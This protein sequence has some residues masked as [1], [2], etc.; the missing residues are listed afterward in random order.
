MKQLGALIFIFVLVAAGM[1]LVDYF[2]KKNLS[3]EVSLDAAELKYFND[4]L[5]GRYLSLVGQPIEGFRPNMFMQVWPGLTESDFDQ[6]ETI[7]GKYEFKNGSLIYT[8]RAGGVK[9]SADEAITGKGMETLLENLSGRLS[10]SLVDSA[11]LDNLLAYL[12]EKEEDPNNATIIGK[13]SIGPICPVEQEGEECE[14]P[15]EVYTSR[16]LVL[17]DKNNDNDL[18]AEKPIGP[19]GIYEF[20]VPAGEYILDLKKSGIDS[21]HDLPKNIEIK[22]GE[23]LTIDLSIDT[24]IR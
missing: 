11:D 22:A 19:D 8:E 18:V 21:S 1:I 10:M 6:V 14:I 12:I 9:T 3:P 13:V 5:Q 15:E 17:Y 20:N 24:G 7:G 2:G 16:I 4:R 23:I